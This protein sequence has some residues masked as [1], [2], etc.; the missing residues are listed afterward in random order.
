[1]SEAGV[2]EV[3]IIDFDLGLKGNELQNA[4]RGVVRKMCERSKKNPAKLN[5]G[6]MA[7]DEEI[8]DRLSRTAVFGS[9][10]EGIEY[11]RDVLGVKDPFAG[12]RWAVG[13]LRSYGFFESVKDSNGKL[14]YLTYLKPGKEKVALVHEAFHIADAIVGGEEAAKKMMMYGRANGVVTAGVAIGVSRAVEG[15]AG[16]LTGED[17]DGALV[18]A[19]VSLS[20]ALVGMAVSGSLVEFENRAM[21]I[22][23][24][25]KIK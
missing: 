12:I 2:G 23:N 13:S 17:R 19:A 21:Q 22:E 9:I 18:A 7:T 1:M 15:I 6:K 16:R 14:H 20:I 10:K 24:E 3:E 8:E 25:V 5:K 11:Q 4:F